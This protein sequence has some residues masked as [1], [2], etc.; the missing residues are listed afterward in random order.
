[1]SV[2][3]RKAPASFRIR[4]DFQDPLLG[5]HN[6]A[7]YGRKSCYDSRNMFKMCS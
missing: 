4:V 3:A 6:T 7:T 2:T 1:M 5:K